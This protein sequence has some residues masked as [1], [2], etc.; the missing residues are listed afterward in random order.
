MNFQTSLPY[1]PDSN[2]HVIEGLDISGT[3]IFQ[4]PGDWRCKPVDMYTLLQGIIERCLAT[5]QADGTYL[6]S[7]VIYNETM[8]GG[9]FSSMSKW[10]ERTYPDGVLNEVSGYVANLLDN[11]P[12]NLLLKAI[13]DKFYSLATCVEGSM[14]NVSCYGVYDEETH[15]FTPYDNLAAI[16]QAAGV[17]FRYDVPGEHNSVLLLTSPARISG[18]DIYGVIGTSDRLFPEV[19]IDRYKVMQVM[20][21]IVPQAYDLIKEHTVAF[22]GESQKIGAYIDEMCYGNDWCEADFYGWHWKDYYKEGKCN[23]TW[24]LFLDV[25][26]NEANWIETTEQ[27][28]FGFN[29]TLWE[30]MFVRYW[31]TS[32]KNYVAWR[33]IFSQTAAKFKIAHYADIPKDLILGGT[34]GGGWDGGVKT[35]DNTPLVVGKNELKKWSEVTGGEVAYRSADG[36]HTPMYFDWNDYAPDGTHDISCS[37]TYFLIADYHFQFCKHSDFGG[38]VTW[39]A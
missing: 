36:F 3:P 35:L 8:G 18:V 1:A 39:T 30:C 15:A 38:D 7:P 33:V 17:S 25:F 19:L 27:A 26:A 32:F 10:T 20:R 2:L 11:Y 5:K 13:D 21:Y 9:E 24:K 34:W 29:R 28:T 12:H 4:R 14:H 16:Y 37:L 6:V 31:G 23:D 22:P